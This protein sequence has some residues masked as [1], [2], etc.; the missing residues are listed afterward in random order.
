MEFQFKEKEAQ[1]SAQIEAQKFAHESQLKEKELQHTMQLEMFKAQ[2]EA[3]LRRYQAEQ[4]MQM[5]AQ[6]FDANQAMAQQE[7]SF[8]AHSMEQD[9][10]FKD[11]EFGHK[12][13][14]ETGKLEFEREKHGQQ[15]QFQQ[16]QADR[17]LVAQGQVPDAE[18]KP[19]GV[20]AL[21]QTM[22]EAAREVK[23]SL[24]HMAA[25]QVQIAEFQERARKGARLVRGADGRATHVENGHG[26]FAIERGPDGRAVGLMQ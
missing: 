5:R 21:V 4:D 6:E 3:E 8:K 7:A 15:M 11:R 23:E 20:A 18:G 12:Q 26:T 24:A 17:E 1:Q 13:Q 10:Q 16:E 14:L 22:T 25:L 19:A 9:A 2:S